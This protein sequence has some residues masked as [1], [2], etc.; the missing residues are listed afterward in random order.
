MVFYIGKN[1]NEILEEFQKGFNQIV[2]SY[3]IV[4]LHCYYVTLTY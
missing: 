3:K 1:W 2:Y 4:W